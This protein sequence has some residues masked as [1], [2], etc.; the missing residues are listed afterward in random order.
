MLYR[1]D[2]LGDNT[3]SNLG[4]GCAKNFE[5]ILDVVS[6]VTNFEKGTL[7]LGIIIYMHELT[8]EQYSI[9]H[10]FSEWCDKD[11]FAVD[12]N[13]IPPDSIFMMYNT[14][15]IGSEHNSS[16]YMYM[17]GNVDCCFIRLPIELKDEFI[18][19]T[20]KFLSNLEV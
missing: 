5:G 20:R 11:K 9:V 14:A 13:S 1:Y 3:G 8:S 19:S 15:S 7:E 4:G 16:V 17:G 10:K 6:E 18:E 12:F 2:S